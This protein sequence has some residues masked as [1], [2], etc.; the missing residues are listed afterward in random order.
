MVKVRLALLVLLALGGGMHGSARAAEA[1]QNPR[2]RPKVL[3]PAEIQTA[4]FRG[5]VD[6]YLFNKN[7][8]KITVLEGPSANGEYEPRMV[9]VA[10]L[11][12]QGNVR[13]ARQPFPIRM[14]VVAGS[15]P[16]KQQVEEF[17]SKLGL[18]SSAAVLDEQRDQDD[19]T[20]S[21][22]RFLG[23]NLQRRTV[24]AAGK[25]KTDYKTLDLAGDYKV[26]L[27]N[28]GRPFGAEEPGMDKVLFPGLVMPRLRLFRLEDR[29]PVY[30]PVERQLKLLQKSIRALAEKRAKR[31]DTP[32]ETFNPFSP[33]NPPEKPGTARAVELPEHC[34]FRV[35]DTTIEPGIVY[36]Y[37]LQIRMANPNW[38]RKDVDRALAEQKE[39][40]SAWMEVPGTVALSPERIYYVVDEKR[41]NPR[42]KP[43]RNDPRWEMWQ[44]ETIPSQQVVL[45]FHR[46]V[47]LASANPKNADEQDQVGDWVIAD[48]VQVARGDYVGQKVKVDLLMWKFSRDSF[49]LLREGANPSPRVPA[50]TG[51][52]VEFGQDRDEG[53]ET[54]L[55]DFR[56]GPQAYQP[57]TAPARV[58]DT[59]RLEVLMLSP[60]G[61]LLARNSA[62]DER[63]KARMI[64]RARW[65]RQVETLKGR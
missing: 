7:F 33:T 36:Q 15:F 9:S 1:E 37:R 35:F 28:C 32:A 8:A 49:V 43:A 55:V 25:P 5:C 64:R 23:L 40:L 65:R 21:A 44:Q 31:S 11:G 17:R 30:P 39:L 50:H 20:Q 16:Y 45:Q 27:M 29:E 56:G 22:F 58:F 13:V 42:D 59:S 3:V 38:G 26:W 46:W 48:R 63:S 18:D 51:I 47:E 14:A 62:D 6:A 2:R 41:I 52:E 61:K 57:I 53:K 24:N 4:V 54:I 12:K 60:E 10:E 19:R 34:L